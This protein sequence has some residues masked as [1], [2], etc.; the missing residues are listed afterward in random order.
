MRENLSE[1]FQYTSPDIPVYSR[2]IRLHWFIN[3]TFDCHWYEDLEFIL[4]DDGA[5][6]YFVNDVTYQLSQGMGLFVN[7]NRLHFGGSGK[8]PARDCRYTCLF[9]H[10]SLLQGNSYI[11]KRFVDPFLYDPGRDAVVLSPETGWQLQTLSCLRSLACMVQE[12]SDGYE[13]RL[14]SQFYFLLDLFY[15]NTRAETGIPARRSEAMQRGSRK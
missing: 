3:H 4:I 6:S 13:L 2:A 10:P 12:Q 5:M 7:A 9:L 15:T 1:V 11:E 8:D 14:Q